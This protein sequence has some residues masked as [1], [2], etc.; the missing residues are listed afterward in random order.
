MGQVD[1]DYLSPLKIRGCEVVGT[2]GILS[3]SSEGKAP[4][5]IK[6][7]QWQKCP[8]EAK[9]L[10]SCPAYDGNGMYIAEMRHFLE[11]IE[12]KCSPLLDLE[13]SCRVL[14]VALAARRSAESGIDTW[15][16]VSI[17]AI[18]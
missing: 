6:G 17:R 14:E 18:H 11:C 4:E 16:D 15:N 2:D 7:L 3:W 13:Q 1:L 10:Y 12:G 8:R 9:E 5:V